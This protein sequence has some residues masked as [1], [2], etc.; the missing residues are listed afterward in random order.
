MTKVTWG[1]KSLY[2]TYTSTV[3]AGTQIGEEAENQ[4]ETT[5]G[6]YCWL[7]PSGI[8]SMLSY[9]LKNFLPRVGT[10]HAS[11]QSAMEKMPP[12]AFPQQPD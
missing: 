7:A 5:R 6:P 1:E 2:L 9:T 4:V 3:K 11:C 10:A 8:L 12:Q